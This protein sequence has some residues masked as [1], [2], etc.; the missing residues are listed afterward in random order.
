MA[1]Y[2]MIS[3]VAR[4]VNSLLE[5]LSPI[6]RLRAAHRETAAKI[7]ALQR[8]LDAFQRHLDAADTQMMAVLAL[9][10][11]ASNELRDEMRQLGGGADL[12]RLQEEQKK[13]LARLDRQLAVRDAE[14]GRNL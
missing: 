3:R 9:L 14:P 7:D 2:R 10:V 6:A 8:N 11:N 1:V 12:L 13:L 4:R 5:R